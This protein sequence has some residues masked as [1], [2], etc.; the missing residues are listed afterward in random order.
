MRTEDGG[1]SQHAAVRSGSNG[2]ERPEEGEVML[3]AVPGRRKG[4][5]VLAGAT[6][7]V[8][9]G[10]LA[11]A[12][13]RQEGRAG[14][15]ESPGCGGGMM[16]GGEHQTD[17]QVLHYLFAHRNE[18]RR[19]VRSIDGGVE[20]LTESDNPDVSAQIRTHVE[21]MY[22]RMKEGRPIHARDP[23]FAELFRKAD[24]IVMTTEPTP[25][26]LRV[27]ETSSDPYVADLIRRH[28]EVVTAFLKNGHVEM[29]R[30]HP[31]PEVR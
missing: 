31:L 13:A 25:E 19:T 10:G 2:P 26:G 22:N 9:G 7:A 21:A 18:I 3:K 29:M 28:A 5:L 17:M 23:L 12:E 30:N 14:G 24:R 4:L 6:V 1:F 27:R 15:G 8:V 16:H 20:T 11:L